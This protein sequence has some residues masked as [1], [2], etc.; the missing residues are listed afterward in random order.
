MH[1]LRNALQVVANTYKHTCMYICCFRQF[2][3]DSCL[4]LHRNDFLDA[5]CRLTGGLKLFVTYS[6]TGAGENNEFPSQMLTLQ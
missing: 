5:L 6:Q 2:M 1:V 4:I 3:R